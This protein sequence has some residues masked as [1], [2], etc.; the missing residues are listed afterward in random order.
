MALDSQ[1]IWVATDDDRIAEHCKYHDMQYIMTS[2]EH[3]TGTDRVA[4]AYRKIGIK[5]TTIINV[6]GDEPLIK[7]EDIKKVYDEHSENIY[8]PC[9]GMTKINS[10][11]EFRNPNIIKVVTGIDNSLKYAS[12]SPIPSNKQLDFKGAYKQVCIYAFSSGDLESFYN[13]NKTPLEKIE[14]IEILRF[15]ETGCPVKMVEVS[16]SSVAVDVLEDIK[17]VEEIIRRKDDE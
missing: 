13:T 17:K 15:L 3:P 7:P 4:E 11:V 2:K 5:C 6:Q 10:E 16:D 14:D 1:V 8:T 9:C 12:R